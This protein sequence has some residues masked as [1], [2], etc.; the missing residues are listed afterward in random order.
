MPEVRKSQRGWYAR[1][2]EHHYLQPADGWAQA[3]LLANE[4]ASHLHDVERSLRIL[5]DGE[6][7]HVDV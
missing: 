1:C 6:R 4:H 2:Y 5:G 3:L 7:V